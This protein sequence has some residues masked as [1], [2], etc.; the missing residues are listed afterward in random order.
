MDKTELTKGKGWATWVR[1]NYA[2]LRER[3]GEGWEAGSLGDA[4]SISASSHTLIT[5]SISN[6]FLASAQEA[7]QCSTFTFFQSPSAVELDPMSL[8]IPKAT[9][10]AGL[11]WLSR[12]CVLPVAFHL[13]Q[14]S[15]HRFP[16]CSQTRRPH[17]SSEP[18]QMLFLLPGNLSF[19]ESIIFPFSTPTP[20]HTCSPSPLF[21]Y[22][23]LQCNVFTRYPCHYLGEGLLSPSFKS[24]ERRNYVLLI[25][26]CCA[27]TGTSQVPKKKKK[28]CF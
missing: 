21:C 12:P 18:S 26:S 16:L 14:L 20:T 15:C 13:S 5:Q 4:S 2:L 25:P 10:W 11:H 27:V 8:P 9:V 6:M 17:L 23:G 3:L 1:E 22:S 28:N 19:I 24:P 7:W